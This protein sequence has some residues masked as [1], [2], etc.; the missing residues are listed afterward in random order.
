MSRSAKRYS[1]PML[2]WRSK[3][4]TARSSGT[5][6]LVAA[7]PALL[8]ACAAISSEPVSEKLDPSTATTVIVVSHPV[9]LVSGGGL[10]RSTRDPFAYLAPFETDRMGERV[11][12]LWISAPQAAGT[13]GGPRVLC[14]GAPIPLQPLTPEG[15]PTGPPVHASPGS[16]TPSGADAAELSELHVSHA[17]YLRPVPWNAQWYFHLTTDG[18]RC[19]A[20]ADA[21]AI[22]MPGPAGT[23]QFNA[24]HKAAAML[25][26]F[27]RRF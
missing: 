21:I 26:A 4:R 10:A 1:D 18:L 20:G 9:E 17:P 22:E 7:L 23:E 24:D 6:M 11:L 16:M 19:L 8:G 15:A 13:S 14:N 2:G 12:F 25:S 5:A 3:L 27:A